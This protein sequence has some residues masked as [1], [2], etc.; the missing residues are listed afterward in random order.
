MNPHHYAKQRAKDLTRQNGDPYAVNLARVL[1]EEAAAA[2]GGASSA[3]PYSMGGGGTVLEHRFGAVLLSHL[4]TRRPVPALG[5]HITPTHV[6]FQGRNISKVDDILVRGRSA[7][8]AE[9]LLSVGVRR[10]P[11][12]V[13]SEADSVQLIRSYLDVVVGDWPLLQ[14]GRQR[15]ALAVVPAC[16]PAH[17]LAALAGVAAAEPTPAEFRRRMAAGGGYANKGVRGRLAQLDTLVAAALRPGLAGGAACSPDVLTWR[18]LSKLSLI[19]LRLEGADLSDRTE[20]VARLQQLTPDGLPSE[21]DALFSRLA[22]L[23][24]IYAPEGAEVSLPSLTAD[25]HGLAC[26]APLA[27]AKGAL[28]KA[29]ASGVPQEAKSHE[30]RGRTGSG[31]QQF[32]LWR[33][34]TVSGKALQPVLESGTLVVRDGYWLVGFDRTAGKRIWALQTAFDALPVTGSGQVFVADR[35]GRVVPIDARTGRKGRPLPIHM[36]DGSAVVDRGTLFTAAPDAHVH[37]LDLASRVPLWTRPV[38]GVPAGPPRVCAGRVFLQTCHGSNGG[39]GTSMDGDLWAFSADGSLHM[40]AVQEGELLHWAVDDSNVYVV[41]RNQPGQSRITALDS[42]S[43][44]MRWYHSFDGDLAGKPALA[45]RSV[46]VTTTGGDMVALASDTGREL[47]RTGAGVRAAAAA[48]VCDGVVYL[49]LW[50]P[51]EFIALDADSGAQLWRKRTSGSFVS[52]P[53]TASGVVYACHRG[54]LTHGWDTRSGKEV[55][56]AEVMWDEA[57]QGSSLVTSGTAYV[58]GSG[59]ELLALSLHAT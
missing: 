56:R 4:L 27:G 29:K 52:A 3:G 2:S 26:F 45:R 8:G 24:G 30:A 38:G 59:G 36:T 15:L 34:P 50:Q 39:D 43:G 17:Q 16:Q 5:D 37:A 12:L 33:A 9:H 22:E 44:R 54:G 58:T 42:D 51:R 7:T 53:F 49:G 6:R 35:S 20:A 55:R 1:R 40:H 31:R 21:A 46:Y 25:L 23:V 19:E 13:P 41:S 47:W 48:R 10:R 32:T 28:G 57:R 18:L 11:R 14:S